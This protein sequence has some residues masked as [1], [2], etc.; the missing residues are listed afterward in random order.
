VLIY[1]TDTDIIKFLKRCGEALATG[2]IIVL[3]E[4]T[5]DEELFVLDKDDASVTRSL[6][7]LL[8]LVKAADLSVIHH[9]I[10][11]DFPDEIF[12]VPMIAVSKG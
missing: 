3:K 8:Q 4:N 12:D 7:F 6:P 9:E 2:G 10:Q 5:C 11:K 1:L